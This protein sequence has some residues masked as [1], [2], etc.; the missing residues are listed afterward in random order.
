MGPSGD[1]QWIDISKVE[2]ILSYSKE[3]GQASSTSEVKHWNQRIKASLSQI[4]TTTPESVINT[5]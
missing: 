4:H 1:F 3:D 2:E 5:L